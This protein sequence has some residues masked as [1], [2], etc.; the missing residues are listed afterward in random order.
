MSDEKKAIT[1]YVETVPHPW[2][3]NKDISYEQV[4]TLEVAEQQVGFRNVYEAEGYGHGPFPSSS[5]SSSASSAQPV[6]LRNKAGWI[7]RHRSRRMASLRHIS[8]RQAR[9]RRM[10]PA[11]RCSEKKS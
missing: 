4:V 11:W 5:N 1:I 10:S 2:P 8:S 9:P 3:K 6:S 7:Q